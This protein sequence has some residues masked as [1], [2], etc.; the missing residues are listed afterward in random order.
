MASEKHTIASAYNETAR[1]V[2]DSREGGREA[3][4]AALVLLRPDQFV[5]WTSDGG[6]ADA[7]AVL[8]RAAGYLGRPA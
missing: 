1:P 4:E 5:A 7:A 2:A 6:A 8:R 3:Y